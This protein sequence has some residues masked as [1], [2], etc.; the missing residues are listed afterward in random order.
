MN[1]EIKITFNNCGKEDKPSLEKSNKDW[2]C[3][4][5]GIFKINTPGKMLLF[6]RKGNLYELIKTLKQ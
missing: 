2:M 1:R 6:G 3:K 4:C 5:G